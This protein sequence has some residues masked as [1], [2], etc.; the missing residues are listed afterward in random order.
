MAPSS[1]VHKTPVNKTMRPLEWGMLVL[2]SVLWGGSFF[3]NG[4]AVMALPTFTVVVCRV[5]LAALTL[6]AVMRIMGQRLPTSGRVWAAFFGMGFLNNVVPFSLIVWGQSHIA[7]GVASILNATTPLFTVLVADVL[8]RDEKITGARLLGVIAGLAGVAVM[9]GGGALS[10]G[11]NITAQ[12]AV[13][14]AALSYAFAGV[15]GRRFQG[16]GITPMAAAT[17]QVTASSIL[18][19]P[20]MLIVDQPWTLAAPSLTVVLALAGLA[21]LST[22]L[23]YILY[24]RILATAGATNLL[25]VTFLIPVSAIGLG[26][27]VLN[28]VLLPQHV[29]GMALIGLGLAAIDGRPARALKTLLAIK[30]REG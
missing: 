28:E 29:A 8:T 19:M 5:F 30:G 23:A 26:V 20:V 25:L 4:V 11:V 17:G 18:L 21:M 10:L 13:L 9:I 2:L 16:L 12:L 6:L 14:G 24:F 1:P 27:V 3:F 7:S 22:A 15:F